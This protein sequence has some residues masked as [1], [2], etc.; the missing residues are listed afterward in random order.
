MPPRDRFLRSVLWLSAAGNLAGA[1]LFAF[2]DSALGRLAGLP[3]EAPEL[4]RSMVALFI[5]LFGAAY[6]W[7]AAQD[8][9]DRPFVLFGAIG[10]TCAFAVVL[11]LWLTGEASARSVATMSGD[12]VF[13]ALLAY[14]L[15][16]ARP[17]G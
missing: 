13:A 17:A 2:P 15:S 3:P 12:L 10:K 5:L 6:S 4:Y 7:L 9:I 1:M 11:V 14:G 8:T 16:I